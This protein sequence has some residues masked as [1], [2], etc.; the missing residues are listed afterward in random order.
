M[1]YQ[2]NKI[3][4]KI[5]SNATPEVEQDKIHMKVKAEIGKDVLKKNNKEKK[6]ASDNKNIK[7][8]ELK[9]EAERYQNINEENHTGVFLDKRK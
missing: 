7:E 3:N 4:P 8:K 1:E 6:N 5:R 9:I 2:L